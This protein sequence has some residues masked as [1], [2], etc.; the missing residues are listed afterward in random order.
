MSGLK[1]E[2]YSCCGYSVEIS[3]YTVEV[4]DGRR[5]HRV[6]CKLCGDAFVVPGDVQAARNAIP[7][8]FLTTHL[9]TG[10]RDCRRTGE[11]VY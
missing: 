7:T 4:A 8:H 3:G 2:F 10:P 6:H 11:G 9:L 1:A 5:G